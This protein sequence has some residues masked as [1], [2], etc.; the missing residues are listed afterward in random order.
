MQDEKMQEMVKSYS[1]H[2]F[3]I[4]PLKER[5]KTPNISSWLKYSKQKPVASEIQG[6]LDQGLFENLGVVCGAV[7]RRRQQT[8]QA[9]IFTDEAVVGR[10]YRHDSAI[11][12]R[13]A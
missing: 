7:K 13:R 9:C 5:E 8:N 3:S 12:W 11:G 1:S 2:G 4:I 6:W 10:L